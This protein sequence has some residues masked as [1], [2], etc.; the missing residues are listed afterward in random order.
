MV[1]VSY[2]HNFMRVRLTFN[3][4]AGGD[5][6]YGRDYNYLAQLSYKFII[7][8]GIS[9]I[10]GLVFTIISALVSTDKN[11]LQVQKSVI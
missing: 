9:F 11:K 6:A 2:F 8:A 1:L 7:S 10:F 3:A 5:A 4:L